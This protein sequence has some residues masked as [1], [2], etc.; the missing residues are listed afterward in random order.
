MNITKDMLSSYCKE[1]GQVKKLIPKLKDK[2]KYVPHYR[3]LHLCLD[4]GLKLKKGSPS[5]KFSL[6]AWLKQCID[7]KINWK[8]TPSSLLKTAYLVKLWQILA[9]P[10]SVKQYSKTEKQNKIN[11]NVTQKS[12]FQNDY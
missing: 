4:L 12:I 9:F 2:K 6:S 8:K 11:I 10:V 1:I 3:N 5:I 7:F